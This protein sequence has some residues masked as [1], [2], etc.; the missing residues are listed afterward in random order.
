[1]NRLVKTAA[2][3]LVGA[4]L[5]APQ[6]AVYTAYAAETTESEET[7]AVQS[8]PVITTYSVSYAGGGKATRIGENAKFNLSLTI[9]DLGVKSGQVSSGSE[10]DF[11]KTLD[12]FT[13]SVK[14]ITKKEN[15]G[16]WLEFT[17]DLENCKW[18]GGSNEFGFMLGYSAAG[19]SGLDYTT[20]SFN[21]TECQSSTGG[22]SSSDDVYAEPIFKISSKKTDVPIKAGQEG[23][24]ELVLKNLGPV[25][26][27]RV[28]VEVSASD[29]TIITKGSDSQEISHII[30]GDSASL[31]IT[32][33]ALDKINTSKQTF[34]ISVKYYYESG[35]SEVTGTASGTVS[36]ASDI[37]TTEKVYPVVMTSFSLSERELQPNTVYEGT[38]TVK[39]IGTADMKGIF[40]S[41]TGGDSFI[42]TGGTSSCYIPEIAVN[43]SVEI[44]IKIKTLN[45][46]ASLS[47]NLGM[48]LK[49]TYV[50]GSD[51][52]DG[53]TEEVFTMFAPISDGT[54]PRP[55]VSIA[56][57]DRAIESGHKYKFYIYTQN[58]G[59]VDMTNVKLSIKGSDGLI[60][61]N[62]TDTAY[63]DSIKEG[64]KKGVAIEFQTA[65]E[66]TSPTQSFTVDMSYSYTVA[67]KTTEAEQSTVHSID[68][69]VSGAPVVRLFGE[70]M[71]TLLMPDTEYTYNIS[72]KNLGDLA[73]KN[74]YI[75]FTAS[76]SVYFLDGTQ[77]A[78]IDSI[79][80]GGSKDVSIRFRTTE[81]IGSFKQDIGASFKYSFGRETAMMSGEGTSTITLIASTDG[82]AA[83]SGNTA[84]PNVIIGSYD[85]GADQIAAGDVFDLSLDF[86]NTSSQTAIENL[87][88]TVNAGGDLNIYGGGNTY[89][90]Q[91]LAAAGAVHE[92]ISLR[93][94]PTAAT[95]TS[96][97]SISFKYDY[98]DGDQRNTV[99]AEQTLY[100]PVY[101]PDKI[102]FDVQ[103][104]TYSIM[105]G[106]EVY[107]TTSYLNKG[108]CDIANVKA[109][110]VGDVS[111][112]STSKIIGNVAPGGNGTFDF[113]VTPFVG[114][115]C[116]FTILITYEDA[117]LEEVQK[118]IPVSFMVEEMMGDEPIWDD[119]PMTMEE[120]GAGNG[121]PWLILW[122]GVGVVV[123]A[124][125]IIIICV[126]RHK[127]KKGKKLT[128]ADIDWEDDLD[129]VL[130][131]NDS[132]KV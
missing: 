110:I 55:V 71:G 77:Y 57:I 40:A 123:V 70:N 116:S 6:S 26:A 43:E 7:A 42:L 78:F 15:S 22:G 10:I 14:Q 115:E 118:E 95:G 104:P 49:Y 23:S 61:L 8:K 101:Q 36:V 63:I 11:I 12:G 16:E 29:D 85:I 69:K 93:S 113:I 81:K 119:M 74:L 86:Y 99:T 68:A 4:A 25:T 72:V 37:S 28:L 125:V 66:L 75:D 94:M 103:V 62:G 100:V 41:F 30:S 13:G 33:K 53:S 122:I 59:D 31:D 117:N 107:I 65:A 127:K 96:A 58:N 129:S 51:E 98:L 120:E 34:N 46:I 35:V 54:A 79:K 24:F 38:V 128:E 89:F 131:D 73:V 2:A 105:A 48:S 1:M 3:L 44:P 52:I 64:K 50:M 9:R 126:V 84:A 90:Y 21:I 130:S 88:M 5:L 124:A 27:D 76:D 108:R 56:G 111:A 132:H 47:Q 109:E 121:F 19:L 17:V 45:E 91:N 114:G 32:Y 82:G 80:A 20:N 92:T 106:N 67:G 18:N 97:V 83:G 60:I 87:I 112:L 102:T 39:N